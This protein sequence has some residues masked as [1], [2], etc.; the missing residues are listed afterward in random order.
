MFHNVHTN[1][2]FSYN[3]CYKIISKHKWF[4]HKT[5]EIAK[6]WKSY[7]YSQLC[8]CIVFTVCL[9][10]NLCFHCLCRCCSCFMRGKKTFSLVF[11][12]FY[13]FFAPILRYIAYNGIAKF[14]CL[15]FTS[16]CECV[17]LVYSKTDS[18]KTGWV[19]L[20]LGI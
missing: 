18:A 16:L 2:I 3:M 10:W 19:H 5:N 1:C 20:V 8:D 17:T 13:S 15:L 7:S 6:S 9:I 11:I 4:D 14:A 12:L